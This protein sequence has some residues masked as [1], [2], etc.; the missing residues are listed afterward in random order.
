MKTTKQAATKIAT[1]SIPEL[2]LLMASD[3]LR[4]RWTPD[5][6]AILRAYY[7]KVPVKML[8]KYLPGRTSSAIYRRGRMILDE[9]A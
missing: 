8:A 7:Q 3:P 5:E 9:L 6:D 4:R 1:V 2:D